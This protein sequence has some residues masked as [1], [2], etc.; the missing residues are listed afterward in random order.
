MATWAELSADS[1]ESAKTL[2]EDKQMRSSV[3]RAYYA[4][5]SATTFELSRTSGVTFAHGRNNPSHEQLPAL[6]RHNLN[7]HRFSNAARRDLNTALRRLR[8]A[9]VEADYVPSAC[10]D[11]YVARNRL[12]DAFFVLERMSMA[13]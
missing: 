11:I 6:V 8:F 12:R 1:F 9:R 5:Y 13:V 7:R 10:C 3:S 4:A 2:L